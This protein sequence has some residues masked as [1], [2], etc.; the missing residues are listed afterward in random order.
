[1]AD[2]VAESINSILIPVELN[3]PEDES[4]TVIYGA[5]LAL[6]HNMGLLLASMKQS[7]A[8]E[9]YREII[10][11]IMG[12]TRRANIRILRKKK[13]E[14]VIKKPEK[15]RIKLI[16][17]CSKN[18]EQ[19]TFTPLKKTSARLLEKSP[20]PVLVHPAGRGYT[21]VRKILYGTDFHPFD[22]E[23]MKSLSELFDDKNPE[24]TALHITRDLNFDKKLKQAGYLKTIKSKVHNPNLKINIMVTREKA[25]IPNNILSLAV[26]NDA[27]LIAILK[28]PGNFVGTLLKTSI[29]HELATRSAIPLMVYSVA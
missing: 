23:V 28:E 13:A 14:N 2:Q 7:N 24:I 26:G 21:P 5:K 16:I 9:D 29:T 15:H 27:D 6:E 20:V 12:D 3:H 11:G 4:D 22:I 19:Q 17:L 18:L 25:S 10:H 1:M 8:L